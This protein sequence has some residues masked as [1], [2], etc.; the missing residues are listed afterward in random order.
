MGVRTPKSELARKVMGEYTFRTH[1]G[2][3]F[4]TCRYCGLEYVY[5]ITRLTT[6]FTGDHE[7]RGGA[8]QPRKGSVKHVK[9]CGSVPYAVKEA[10]RSLHR[11]K[12]SKQREIREDSER[13]SASA[14]PDEEDRD[15]QREFARTLLE[16]NLS[17]TPANEPTP[18]Q[19]S[20]HTSPSTAA[21]VSANLP[22]NPS[23]L[24]DITSSRRHIQQPLRPMMDAA[25]RKIADEKWSM[26]LSVMGLPFRTL[27]HPMFREAYNFSSKLPGYKF[28]SSTALRTT[29][30]DKNFN[31]VKK[32]AEQNMWGHN[33]CVRATVS[34]DGWTN[35]NGRPQVNLVIVNRYGE[36]VY[37]HA[38]GSNV[39]KDAKWVAANMIKVIREVGPKNVLQFTAD[40]AA[41]NSL[42]GQIVRAEFPHIVFGGCV[43]HGIDLLFED[44]AKLP[45]IKAIFSKCNEIVCFIK[46]SHQPHTMLMDFFSDGATLL[47]PGITRFA[48]SIIMLDRT[49]HLEH[50]LKRMVVSER[51]KTW[52]TDSRRPSKTRIKAES[53]K[54]IILDDTY[55]NKCHDVL[56]MVEPVYRLLRQVDAHKDFM[57]RIFWESWETQESIRDLWKHSGLKSNLLSKVRCD[58]VLL[59]FRLRWD[60]WHNI[61]H[62]TAMLLHPSYLF[63]PERHELYGWD[64]ILEDFQEY[65]Q[66]YGEGIL[67]YECDGDELKIWMEKCNDELES[68][69]CQNAAVWTLP[70]KEKALSEKTKNN[71]LAWWGIC[72][73]AAPNLRMVAMDVLGLTTVASACERGCKRHRKTAR[74]LN[75]YYT[76]RVQQTILRRRHGSEYGASGDV[77][78]AW[79]PDRTIEENKFSAETGGNLDDTRLG[80]DAREEVLDDEILDDMRTRA[81]ASTADAID[82]EYELGGDGI[83]DESREQ[84]LRHL[85]DLR[86]EDFVDEDVP[87]TDTFDTDFETDDMNPNHLHGRSFV[88]QSD[89][90]TGD[91][92]ILLEVDTT[93]AL[94]CGVGCIELDDL[95]QRFPRRRLPRVRLNE[96]G[97]LLSTN[98][99]RDL[100]EIYSVPK[101]SG[102]SAKHQQQQS[103]FR[104]SSGESSNPRPSK[105]RRTD[106]TYKTPEYAVPKNPVTSTSE[107]PPQ[108][109]PL[110]I[111]NTHLSTNPPDDTIHSSPERRRSG[112]PLSPVNYKEA[113]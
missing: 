22:R 47:K 93:T 20:T 90:D 34:C 110:S 26:A 23:P 11:N 51:W 44:M 73:K 35:R 102:N 21:N 33:F 36:M 69:A 14:M 7:P 106:T 81:E 9:V 97:V 45:W 100:V 61:I 113:F 91:E 68:I 67:G 12:T 19:R 55:W 89:N 88:S 85:D 10:I 95:N 72:G 66:V 105:V 16:E 56:L 96:P 30:L 99:L 2:Q 13:Q 78:D 29:L 76:S 38:D 1:E 71:P 70:Y 48:T 80:F 82:N 112:R 6:H 63:D 53:I 31:D 62:S 42:A 107:D 32:T 37:D 52:A 57:G 94:R 46:N 28:P 79:I 98:K 17:N 5:N 109:S 75:T 59:L 50:C 49:F 77:R 58:E 64:Y 41:V 15:I 25:Q 74:L 54:Q 4:A 24:S 27:A 111:P 83:F 86:D 104:P 39:T 18:S 8:L 101:T 84:P 60:K 108:A 92:S 103:R 65:I 40:N 3:S 87:P 43:A